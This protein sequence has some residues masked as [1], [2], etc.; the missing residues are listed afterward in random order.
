MCGKMV[1]NFVLWHVIPCNMIRIYQRFVGSCCLHPQGMT[2]WRLQ[3][4]P[5]RQ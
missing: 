3:V 2:R 4:R 5:K 1:K